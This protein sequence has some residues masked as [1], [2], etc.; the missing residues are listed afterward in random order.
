MLLLTAQQTSESRVKV[1]EQGIV[2]LLRKPADGEDGG[3]TSQRA[4][5]VEIEFRLLL[6]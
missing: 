1:L 5:L 4:I 6:Y 2:L 3:L